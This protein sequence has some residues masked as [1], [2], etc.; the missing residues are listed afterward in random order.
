M[1]ATRTT[2]A[3]GCHVYEPT[4][5]DIRQ[6]CEEIQ[7]TWSPRER[8]KRERGPRAARWIPPMIRLS[9]LIEAFN[10]ERADGPLCA[11]V[12]GNEAER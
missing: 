12:V 2:R 5:K 10:G 11:G 7:A 3:L 8:A 1:I 6:A 9:I 4:S